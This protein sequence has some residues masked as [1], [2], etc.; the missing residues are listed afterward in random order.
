[1]TIATFTV[2][3][4]L[5]VKEMPSSGIPVLFFSFFSALFTLHIFAR[6]S[7][8]RML[9]TLRQQMS[10]IEVVV[11]P[12]LVLRGRRYPLGIPK[13]SPSNQHVQ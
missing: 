9:R 10:D 1:M 12:S 8:E 11:V 4:Y 2:S 13:D 7:Q 3:V 5:F 6:Y